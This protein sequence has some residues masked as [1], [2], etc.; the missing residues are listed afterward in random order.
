MAAVPV[1]IGFIPFGSLL[2]TQAAQKGLTVMKL[3]L[4]AGLNFGGVLSFQHYRSG[5]RHLMF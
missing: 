5:P 1:M 2:G 3:M 4:M